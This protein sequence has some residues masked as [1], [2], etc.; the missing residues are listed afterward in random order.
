VGTTGAAFLKLAGSARESALGDAAAAGAQGADA[1]FT[2]PAGLST[3]LP[4]SPSELSLTYDNLLETSYL[5]T[6]AWGLPVGRSGAFGA[7]LVYLSQSALT[8]YSGQGDAVGSFQPYDL[9]LALAYARRFD[10]FALGGSVKMIRS[11]LDD[12]AGTSA[13]LDFGAQAGN[14]CLVGDRPLDVGAYLSNLGPAIKLGSLSA[15]LPFAFTGGALWHLAT[16]V[17]TRMDVHLPSDQAPY[18]SLGVEGTYRFDQQ[19]HS[20][21]LRLGYDQNHSRELDGGAGLTVGGGLDL[22]GFRVDY[23]WVPYGGL[24]MENRFTLAFRF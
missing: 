15:P 19:K 7:D 24:G 5:G 3:L 16:A 11:S 14:V 2:N 20:A 10:G 1:L 18:V 13:A 17:D 23:A 8:A 6:A 21:S 9:A 12:V 4:E 22:G